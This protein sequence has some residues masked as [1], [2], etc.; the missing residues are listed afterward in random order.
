MPKGTSSFKLQSASTNDP[1]MKGVYL[2]NRSE[3][4]ETKTPARKEALVFFRAQ[5]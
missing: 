5:R 3:R 2:K 1:Q 4:S